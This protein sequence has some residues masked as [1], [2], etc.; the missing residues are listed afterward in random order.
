MVEGLRRAGLSETVTVL[1]DS[2]QAWIHLS[3]ESR[4]DL[5]F[6]DLNLAPLSGLELLERIRSDPKLETV[7]VII[8][9]GSQNREDVHRA[10]RLG[11]N[12][13]LTK[14]GNLDDFLAFMKM[15]YELWGGVATLPR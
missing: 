13:Y 2:G 4:P 7:P 1:E 3:K 15:S 6:L 11:A 10:Y 9:S 5:I 8:V 14:P 12:C